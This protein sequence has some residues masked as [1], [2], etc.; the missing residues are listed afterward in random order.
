MLAGALIDPAVKEDEGAQSVEYKLCYSVDFSAGSEKCYVY[1]AFFEVTIVHST[2]YETLF[3]QYESVSLSEYETVNP[4][5]KLRWKSKK[6]RS[7]PP[8]DFQW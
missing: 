8:D 7:R 6:R 2:V 1:T 4:D 5:L 3:P